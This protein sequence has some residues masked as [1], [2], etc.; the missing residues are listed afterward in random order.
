MVS[1]TFL[2]KVSFKDEFLIENIK[3]V[4][5]AV[6]KARPALDKGQYFKKISV[7]STMDP[8]ILIDH[9]TL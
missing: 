8:S 7:S 9:L 1:Y 6:L 4:Y 3:A 5:E 2:C